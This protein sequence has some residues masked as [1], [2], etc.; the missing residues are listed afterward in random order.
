VQYFASFNVA[1]QIFDALITWNIIGKLEVTKVSLK[2]FQ[3]FDKKI[4]V[5]VYRKDSKTYDRLTYALKTWAENTL[6]SLAERT[7][8]DLVLP[9]IMNKTTGEPVPPRGALRSQV[10]VL[11]AYNSH[12]GV[13]PPSWANGYPRAKKLWME[14]PLN[15][16]SDLQ[17]EHCGGASDSD[18]GQINFRF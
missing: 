10:A 7:P 6:L 11:G 2:F 13:I 1:E 12:N 14:M 3:Q 5:G 17:R 16:D 4:K 8:Q 18:D 9:L 15:D